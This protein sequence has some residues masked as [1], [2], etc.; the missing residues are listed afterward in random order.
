MLAGAIAALS[1]ATAHAGPAMVFSGG[2]ILTMAGE[3]PA[4]VEALAVRDGRILS[5]GDLG[6]VLRAAGRGAARVDLH[7]RAL[8]PG[9]I[10]AHGHVSMVGQVGRLVR[11]SPPPA[12]GVGSLTQ[13]QAALREKLAL[14]PQETGI[15]AGFGYDDSQLTERRHPTRHDLDAVSDRRPIL[16]AH[17]SGHLAVANTPMLALLGMSTA[18]PDPEGGVIRR[19][20]DG[21]TPNGV[22]EESAV[23]L[24]M[25]RL[26]PADLD[27]AVDDLVAAERIYAGFGMT[28]AQDGRVMPEAWPVLAEASRRG[29]LMLDTVALMAVERDWPE[30]VK[31]RIGAPYTGRL[32]IA[33]VKFSLDGSPQ[34]RTAW[35]HDPVPVP[36]E[37]QKDGYRG[38]PAMSAKALGEGLAQA[39]ARDWQVFAHVNGDEAMEAL[40][41]GVRKAGLDGRR[42]I[43]I[44]SQ[45]VREDQ[46]ARMRELDIQPSFFASHT[47]FWG[48]W[49]RDVALGPVRA[50][51]ISPQASAWRLGLRPTAHNDAPVV[52]PDIARLIWSSVNRRTQSGDILGPQERI[53]TYQALVQVTRNAAWQIHEEASK[54]TLEPGKL[55]DLVVLDQDPLRA[56]PDALKDLQVVTTLKEGRVIFGALPK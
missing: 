41:E 40:I 46:L 6:P 14:E 12:G 33:G 56:S 51:R 37:G 5:T 48:D 43:A 16:I 7:G 30:A 52:A 27:A 32:R 49:H 22:L 26:A 20:A 55:A 3:E 19:E 1:A 13:L 23:A 53:S 42:T 38:Y 4:Y 15:L 2:P 21:L 28:T 29:V 24:A 36:P 11:L 35:L 17:A 50:D 39:A 45:V 25:R 34:G 10:D 47:W 54:G 9:F 18:T 44:H 8:L 31:A